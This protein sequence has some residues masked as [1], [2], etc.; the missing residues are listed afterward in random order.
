MLYRFTVG[1]PLDTLREY[2]TM[3]GTKKGCDHGQCGACTVLSNGKRILGC[4]EMGTVGMPPLIA[5]AVYYATGKRVNQIPI[6]FDTLINNPYNKLPHGK[7]PPKHDRWLFCLL[8]FFLF[9]NQEGNYYRGDSS[10]YSQF[11]Y[12]SFAVVFPS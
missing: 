9:S 11:N 5:S 3:G 1:F 7:K 12:L 2:L 10:A 6:H 4:R 8:L